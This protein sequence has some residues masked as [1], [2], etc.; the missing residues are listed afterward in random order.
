MQTTPTETKE[1]PKATLC[2]AARLLMFIAAKSHSLA[3]YMGL[4]LI[5][6]T[7]EPETHQP[8]TMRLRYLP[9][10]HRPWLIPKYVDDPTVLTFDPDK[11]AKT[12]NQ[13]SDGETFMRLWLLNVWNPNFA[14]QKGWKFDLF[15]ALNTL[16]SGNRDCIAEWMMNPVWP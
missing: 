7:A 2:D 6:D 4:E 12:R 16:D 14:A 3:D 1:T 8:G 9:G 13:C 10:V 11:F 15:K 5:E